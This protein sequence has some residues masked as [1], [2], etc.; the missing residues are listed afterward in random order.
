MRRGTLEGARAVLAA[1][2]GSSAAQRPGSSGTPLPLPRCTCPP[3]PLDPGGPAIQATP[4][5]VGC[6]V[7]LREAMRRERAQRAEPRDVWTFVQASAERDEVQ[8]EPVD[9]A[10]NG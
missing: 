5:E 4:H 10:R 2:D 1:L 7:E 8:D 6:P 9:S 3:E